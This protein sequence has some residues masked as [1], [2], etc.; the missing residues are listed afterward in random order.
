MQSNRSDA[1]IK[2]YGKVAQ[3]GEPDLQEMAIEQLRNL[4]KVEC[5]DEL[6]EALRVVK[7]RDTKALILG[8]LRALTRADCGDSYKSWAKWWEAA[9]SEGLPAEE[10]KEGGKPGEFS[11]TVVDELDKTR[12]EKLFGAEIRKLKVLV[13][14]DFCDPP[15]PWKGAGGAICFDHIE[16]LTVKMGIETIAILRKEFEKLEYKIP[17]D[18]D[19][20]CVNCVQIHPHCICPFC[21]AGAGKKD[22]MFP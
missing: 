18:V 16:D 5:V 20:V 9:R 3:S 2:F 6:I 12:K 21:T 19:G 10:K 22:R 8:A 11:G 7:S 14:Y 4:E 13:I 1:V 17:A 15:P